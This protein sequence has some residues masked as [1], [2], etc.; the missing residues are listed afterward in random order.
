VAV[1]VGVERITCRRCGA[2]AETEHDGD[3]TV[4]PAGWRHIVVL[5][6]W[7]G[8]RV[9]ED[10]TPYEVTDGF[11]LCAAHERISARLFSPFLVS[12]GAGYLAHPPRK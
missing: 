12:S 6:A 7:E 4:I 2:Y 1:C 3:A 8:I 5:T 9:S 10:L 11:W